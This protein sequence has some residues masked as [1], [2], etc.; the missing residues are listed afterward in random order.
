ME[1][2]IWILIVLLIILFGIPFLVGFFFTLIPFRKLKFWFKRAKNTKSPAFEK[3][4]ITSP[5]CC[6]KL[7]IQCYFSKPADEAKPIILFVHGHTSAFLLK[8]FIVSR[9]FLE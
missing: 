4:K 1:F 9:P 2:Y 8:P 6:T 3:F 7:R 5:G